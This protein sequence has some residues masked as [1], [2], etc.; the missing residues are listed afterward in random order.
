MCCDDA[1]PVTPRAFDLVRYDI[2]V[3]KPAMSFSH[4]PAPWRFHWEIIYPT[5]PKR[6]ICPMTRLRMKRTAYRCRVSVVTP[7][8]QVKEKSPERVPDVELEEDLEE[9]P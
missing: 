9:D 4:V 3:S 7:P 2:L 5:G 1:Y 6:F 8:V